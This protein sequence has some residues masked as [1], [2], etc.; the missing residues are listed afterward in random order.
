[1]P[2]YFLILVL[3][4]FVA[5]VLH[6]VSKVKLYKSRSHFILLNTIMLAVAIFFD[7][8]AIFRGW[9]SFNPKFLLGPKI[10]YMPVEEFVFVFA[11]GYLGL[12]VYK[13]LER[14]CSGKAS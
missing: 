10:G 13:I 11:V 9:W 4:L 1:M 2:E 14:R 7:Q 5:F 3:W 6:R 12:V 8:F